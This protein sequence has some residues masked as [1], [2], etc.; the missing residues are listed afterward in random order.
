MIEL[1]KE[2]VNFFTMCCSPVKDTIVVNDR[3]G[4]GT[5]CAHGDYFT[6]DDRYHPSKLSQVEEHSVGYVQKQ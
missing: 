6:C 2:I 3:W 4:V 5:R 1:V